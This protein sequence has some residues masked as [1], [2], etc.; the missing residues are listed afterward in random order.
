LA[1]VS[2]T[3]Y[4]THWTNIASV[5]N[6][7]DGYPTYDA[8]YINTTGDTMSGPLIVN[9]ASGVVTTGEV[10]ALQVNISTATPTEVQHATRKDYV[11][12]AVGLRVPS[13]RT[14]T[15]TAPLTG[16]GDLSANRTLGISAFAGSAAGAVPASAGGTTNF[17][18]ADGT[19]AAPSGGGAIADGTYGEINVAS[20][21]TIW[22]VVNNSITANDIVTNAVT[23]IK[24]A[25]MASYT[26]KMNNSGSVN[27][28]QDVTMPNLKT[29][30]ALT[31]S[32]VGLSN[33]DNTADASK[34]VSTDQAAADALRV[35]K[36]GDT[37]TGH[38]TM[39]GTPGNSYLKGDI[40][41]ED[42][43]TQV[44]E[45]IGGTQYY[46][47]NSGTTWFRNPITLFADPTAA[48]QATTK[49]YVDAGDAG[50]RSVVAVA[51]TTH[52]FALTNAGN[53]VNFSSASA[54]TATVPPNSSVA[55]PIG[56]RIDLLQSGAG[57]VSTAPGSGVTLNPSSARSIR[58]QWTAATLIKTA[59]DTWVL[60]GDTTT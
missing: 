41:T 14:L 31:K 44:E 1:K 49:Q 30:L 33:V 43:V 35:L 59:T 42:A 34:P 16:G 54:V 50:Y 24:L 46:Y 22:T 38:L 9:H 10:A 60:V 23:N 40:L 47:T 20:G 15:T 37:M 11:D 6:W 5:P 55:F 56:S 7:P 57:K 27:V 58:T 19:W 32:D 25:Q 8:R 4:D 21:G 3:D 36:T 18:R 13:S 48:M 26:V 51:G 45:R 17:L 29:A 53:L 12:T 2:S 28:P 52:T 39:A